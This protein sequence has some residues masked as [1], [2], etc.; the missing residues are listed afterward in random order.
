M[1]HPSCMVSCSLEDVTGLTG[2]IEGMNV[3]S[4]YRGNRMYPS[5]GQ[6][7]PM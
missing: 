5:T 4:D 1:N 6:K 2:I 7:V 3:S